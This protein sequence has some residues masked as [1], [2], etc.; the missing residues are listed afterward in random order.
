MK[1]KLF[2]AVAAV[3]VL[4]AVGL[5]LGGWRLLWP[6]SN[7]LWRIVST[8]CV[9][10]AEAGKTDNTCAVVNLKGGYAVLKDIRGVAQ[11]L[12][13][14]TARISG[15]ESAELLEAGAPNYWRDAWQ[16]RDLVDRRL[17]VTL[18]RN[19]IGLAIN[20]Y[21]GR[22]QNQLHIHIDCMRQDVIAA[23]DAQHGKLGEQW[24]ELP[25]PLAGQRYRARLIASDN[26]DNVDPFKLL[27]AD[28][29]PRGGTMAAQTLLLTGTTLADGK[30]GFILLND[31]VGLG[32]TA[33]AEALLD[34]D[35]KLVKGAAT[36][37]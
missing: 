15:I 26:L 37:G 30:P 31:Q 20:S 11:Y 18:P 2:L 17:G 14:P 16:A 1:K 13:I 33:S 3:I 22:T 32:S 6:G 10:Q 34:H 28:I 29:H 24:T 9:P 12:L 35:C 25:Q 5:G 27:Y 19:E 21:S 7:A 23:L 4:V 8:Q 36:A